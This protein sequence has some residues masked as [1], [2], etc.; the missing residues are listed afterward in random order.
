[1][2]CPHITI[3]R[4][5]NGLCLCMTL[6]F[7]LS[8]Q[9]ETIQVVTEDS[10]YSSLENG[11]VVGAASELVE[12]TLAKAG[13]TDYHMSLYPWARAYDIARLEPNVLIYPIIRSAERETLFKWVGELDEV[14]PL[15]YKLRSRHDIVVNDLQDAAGYTVGVI[16]D[17][18]RQEYLE[19]KGF[20]KMVVSSN[21]LDNLRK[22][23]SGQVML[24]PMP[25]RE[26]R[27]QCQDLQIDFE[28]LESVYTLDDLSKGLYVAMSAK[29][30]DDVFKR[31]STAFSRL[32]DDGTVAKV[33]AQ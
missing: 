6:L 2:S 5:L 23:L 29:T 33:L 3:R 32:K 27:K 26:A 19:R 17:D 15:F 20:S 28:E 9:A 31:V 30:P 22:L 1:M 14:T 25:E 10:S 12:K 24:V 4:S 13:V 21:N 18:A 16:R 11:K 8:A 7:A